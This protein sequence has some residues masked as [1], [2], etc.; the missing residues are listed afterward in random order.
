[1]TAA[2]T[3]L[4]WGEALNAK[5]LSNG[6]KDSRGKAVGMLDLGRDVRSLLLSRCL[7]AQDKKASCHRFS[8]PST[9]S[10]IGGENVRSLQ[11]VVK[12]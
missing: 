4:H 7:N 8:T 10:T 6:I 3:L 5:R 12:G 9:R 1:M 2:P 11:F